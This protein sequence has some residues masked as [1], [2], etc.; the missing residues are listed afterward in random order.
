MVKH[1][2][3]TETIMRCKLTIQARTFL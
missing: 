1:T 2:P 3:L